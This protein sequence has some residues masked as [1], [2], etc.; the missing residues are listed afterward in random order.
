MQAIKTLKQ[1]KSIVTVTKGNSKILG[2]TFSTSPFA[3]KT[4]S[5][6]QNIEGSTCHKCYAV[7][8]AKL[9]PSALVS[10]D[11]NLDSFKTHL[12]NDKL[13]LWCEAVA[14][15]INHWA[16]YK[17]KRNLK[18]ANYHRWFS[19][20]DLDSLEM[21]EA[22]IYIAKLTPNTKHWLP[23]RERGI[24]R[25][26]KNKL[27]V[28]PENLTIRVSDTKIDQQN[29]T[30]LGFVSSSVHKDGAAKG[31]ECPAYKNNGNCGDCSAC[32]DKK[33]ENVSYKLH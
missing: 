27:G 26:F 21:L 25:Q 5:R 3:C 2:S 30:N 17:K 12:K 14:Y 24:L 22:I 15:Q 23:T 9:Y 31:F 13:D 32:W 8:L 1:A 10:W 20:G 16:E 4:G 7:K 11:N 18:G 19:S 33:V 28:I 29:T 6:L